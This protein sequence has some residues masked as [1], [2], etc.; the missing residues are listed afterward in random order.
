[1]LGDLGLEELAVEINSVGHP[2]CRA[3]Y[4]VVLRQ[5]LDAVASELCETCRE[6][7][8]TNPLR[9]FDCKNPACQAVAARLPLLGEHLC[10]E[11]REHHA[12][13][14]AGLAALQVPFRDNPRLVR[15]LD[16][17]TRTAFEVHYPP[18]GAQSA[19]VAVAATTGSSKLA[20]ARRRRRSG[21]RPASNASWWRLRRV[22]I[23][24]MR[25][26]RAFR[27]CSRRSGRRRGGGLWSWRASCA[28]SRRRKSI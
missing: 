7:A 11:C 12:A 8:R 1:M 4:E 21:F 22:P 28:T 18:L 10:D 25:H 15:G 16:Y 20:A 19:L 24:A 2:G 14:R 23:Q 9:V 5:A 6:R 17:Y 13:V 3:A 27:S 26:R